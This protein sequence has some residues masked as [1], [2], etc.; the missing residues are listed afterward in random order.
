M[1]M[2]L[3]FSIDD[4][5]APPVSPIYCSSVEEMDVYAQSA[6]AAAS[7][8]DDSDGEVFACFRQLPVQLQEQIAERQ[9]TTGLSGCA[10]NEFPDFPWEDFKSILQ[11]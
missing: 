4:L 9:M 3:Q 2:N 6:E 8:T 11:M 1:E 5:T 7:S 10:D